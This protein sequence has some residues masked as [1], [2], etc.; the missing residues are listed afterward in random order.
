MKRLFISVLT[1]ALIGMVSS[2]S[3]NDD[4]VIPV[5]PPTDGGGDNGGDGGGQTTD[6]TLTGNISEDKTLT[7]DGIWEL[8]GRVAVTDGATLTIEPGTIIKAFPGTGANAS[9]LIIAR[10]AKIM[11][12]GT[13]DKPIIMTSIGDDIEL[14]QKFGTNLG[15]ND[16]ALWGGLLILG[17]AKGSFSGDSPENQIEGIPADD[18]NG[19]YGGSDDEDNSGV[20]NY[21]SI[22]HGGALIGEGNEING[23]T[24]GAVGSGTSIS[25]VEIVG[26]LDDGIEFFGGTV[27]VSNA[28]IYAV[29]DD[30]LDI[31]Q[32]Y[33]GTITNSAVI[34]GTESDHGLEIDGGEGSYQA[35]FTM[36]GI[37]LMGNLDADEGKAY[38]ADLRD[39]AQGIISNVYATGFK[40]ESNLELDNNGIA[41]NF[42]DGKL[43]FEN[44][45]INLPDGVTDPGSIFQEKTGDDESLIITPS[46]TEQAAAWATVGTS[47]G[48]DLSVFAWTFAKSKNAY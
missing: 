12:E 32:A 13:A 14:G 48:A 4:D 28:L 9:T 17:K 18:T 7:A 8:K 45:V 39:N 6:Y 36:D 22:R 33:S 26:N 19:L 5:D 10:G 47:G 38:Y 24:L 44:W 3:N 11:A 34:E 1:V 25:N 23:L 29:G 30:G 35:G 42:I 16:R 2:C 41:Q 27:N 15:A 43:V 31:D 20:V 40:V 37:T 21:I 46:F